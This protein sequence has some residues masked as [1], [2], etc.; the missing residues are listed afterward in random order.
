MNPLIIL[1]TCRVPGHVLLHS[2]GLALGRPAPRHAPA[3]FVP[4]DSPGE[5][6]A[7][8]V[9]QGLA[10]AGVVE[11]ERAAASV[12]EP[13]VQAAVSAHALPGL[14]VEERSEEHTS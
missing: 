3:V 8:S 12:R 2:S 6:A 1:I 14:A 13:P 10:V 11:L 4:A 9:V 7:D 5:P